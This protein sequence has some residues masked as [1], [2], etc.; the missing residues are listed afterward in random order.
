MAATILPHCICAH[1]IIYPLLVLYSATNKC[2]GI[3][4]AW[5]PVAA[6]LFPREFT[7]EETTNY[8]HAKQFPQR[9]VDKD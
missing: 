4:P 5:H 3:T 6:K 7:G 9:K 2:W 8:E 1:R